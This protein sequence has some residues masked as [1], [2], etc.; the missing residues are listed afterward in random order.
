MIL[1]SRNEKCWQNWIWQKEISLENKS[2]GRI[3]FDKKENRENEGC[4]G[5]I[6]LEKPENLEKI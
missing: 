2:V 6:K 5:G 1:N 3:T 4:V